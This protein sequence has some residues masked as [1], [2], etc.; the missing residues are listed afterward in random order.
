MAFQSM[1]KRS[2]AP[3][4]LSN[5]V[6]LSRRKD[7]VTI[8]M[9]RSDADRLGLAK[10]GVHVDLLADVSVG[11][12]RMAVV[13]GEGGVQFRWD[14]ATPSAQRTIDLDMAIRLCPIEKKGYDYTFVPDPA[15]INKQY[16]E[17]DLP[18]L[19]KD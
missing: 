12:F 17:M 6:Q 13:D 7:A 16:I 3:T 4:A 9:K 18:P 8:K 2:F 1:S 19:P 15:S 5:V 11:K 14:R 10:E